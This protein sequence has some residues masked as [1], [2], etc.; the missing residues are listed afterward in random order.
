MERTVMKTF[1][2]P[3]LLT[4]LLGFAAPSQADELKTGIGGALGGAAG[5]AVGQKLGGN[6][7]A[8]VGGAVGGGV[9]AGVAS[10]SKDKTGAVV[11][12]AVGGAGGALAG[13]KMGGKTGA[14]VGA[15]LGAGAGAALGE[16]LTKD[17]RRGDRYDGRGRQG[18]GAHPAC[19][20]RK[21]GHYKH[22]KFNK[23]GC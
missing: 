1:A 20:G 11:G 19:N 15:G 22:G 5:A 3:L 21:E 2:L 8:V 14:V 23:H 7:G 17:S 4:A 18:G 10:N 6:T 13:Q 9:G 12:G 16:N